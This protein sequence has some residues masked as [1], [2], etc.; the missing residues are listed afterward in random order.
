[1]YPSVG[2]VLQLPLSLAVHVCSVYWVREEGRL[3]G[4]SYYFTRAKPVRW[5]S[6]RPCTVI[7]PASSVIPT[8]AH[9]RGL[10]ALKPS[11]SS[12]SQI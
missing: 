6:L 11:S 5:V 4:C 12:L 7:V 1:V 2:G 10:G 8:L 3:K 9:T